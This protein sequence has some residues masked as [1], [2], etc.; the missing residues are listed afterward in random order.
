M[1]KPYSIHQQPFPVAST[2]LLES[3]TLPVAV[4]VN[5]RTRGRV[6]VAPDAS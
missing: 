6:H 1:G 5:G 4:Q 3:R 2:S